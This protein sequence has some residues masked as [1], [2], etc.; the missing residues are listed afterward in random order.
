MIINNQFMDIEQTLPV[1]ARVVRSDRTSDENAVN[2]IKE[3]LIKEHLIEVNINET[4]VLRLVCTPN[5]LPELVLGRLVTEGFIKSRDDVESLYICENGNR[6]RIYLKQGMELADRKAEPQTEPTCCTDNKV[7]GSFYAA[8]ELC[9]L[10]CAEY[11]DKSIFELIA[12]FSENSSLHRK[13]KGTH[14]CYLSHQGKYQEVFEDIGRHNALD[15]AVGYALIKGFDFKHCILFTT[16]RV[17]VDM[18][19]KAVMAGIPILVSKAVPTVE[20]VELAR[21]FHLTLICKAWPDSYEIYNE[22]K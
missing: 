4:P 12:K 2:P 13:T 9:E 11:S 17:P 21:R 7:L 16:G 15:K 20:A 22:A 19:R 18:V 6:A 3:Q 5:R 14:S 10:P 1:E 8:K